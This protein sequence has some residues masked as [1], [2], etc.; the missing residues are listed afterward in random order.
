[1]DTWDKIVEQLK[2]WGASDE[3]TPQTLGQAIRFCEAFKSILPAPESVVTT[4]DG[5]AAL[6][7]NAEK[8]RITVE[9]SGSKRFE[10]TLF[11][12]V[13]VFAEFNGTATYR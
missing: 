1:M 5:D 8:N 9:L 12:L 11:G 7:W 3:I 10:V 2:K 6:S 13:L 4:S